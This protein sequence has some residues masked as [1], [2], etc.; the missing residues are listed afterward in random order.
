M[1]RLAKSATV[2]SGTVTT[3]SWHLK[4][5][6]TT[7]EMYESGISRRP[8]M[9]RRRRQIETYCQVRTRQSSLCES[10][11]ASENRLLKESGSMV[12]LSSASC[13]SSSMTFSLRAWK[14]SAEGD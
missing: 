5:T 14:S 13:R 11:I 4:S 9:I 12:P 3:R 1:G 10:V 7:Q 8:S 6:G 2:I